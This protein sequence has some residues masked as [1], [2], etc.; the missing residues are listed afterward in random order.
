MA[1]L[2]SKIPAYLAHPASGQARVRVNGRDFYLGPYGSPESKQA[3]ARFIV[4]NLGNGSP[5][6]M[7][8]LKGG[9]LCIAALIVKY[10]DFARSYYVKNGRPTEERYVI[11]A[12]VV[13]LFAST[14]TLPRTNSVPN[15]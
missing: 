9:M 6:K 5:P 13:L 2:K 1:R 4:E 11:K 14:A 3:Y 7:G 12:A 10:D 8:T 15:G